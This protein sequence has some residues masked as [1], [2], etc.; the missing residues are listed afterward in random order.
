MSDDAF[1]PNE[2]TWARVDELKRVAN[3]YL[4]EH[5]HEIPK[6]RLL[7]VAHYEVIRDPG[8]TFPEHEPALTHLSNS[9]RLRNG[10]TLVGLLL[11][12]ALAVAAGPLLINGLMWEAAICFVIACILLSASLLSRTKLLRRYSGRPLV[13]QRSAPRRRSEKHDLP[14]PNQPQD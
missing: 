5:H 12:F 1:T 10:F 9:D 6:I 4:D 14:N 11:G 8:T 3:R 7:P 13:H 2:D